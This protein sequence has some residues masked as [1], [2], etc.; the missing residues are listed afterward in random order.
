MNK[1]FLFSIILVASVFL[2]SLSQVLL[3]ISSRKVYLSRLREYLNPLVVSAYGLF[4]G[5]TFVTM[6]ALK[7]VPLSMAPILEAS[8]YLFVAIL[9]KFV[10]HESISRKKAIGL[11]LIITG[12]VIYAV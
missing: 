4:L 10:L 11:L 6:Y 3:K 7:V 12:V 5:C 2:S 1:L 9:S 8:G